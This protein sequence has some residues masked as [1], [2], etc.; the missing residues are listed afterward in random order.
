M[1]TNKERI[2]R[3]ETKLGGMQNE[4]QRL[5]QGMN[6]KFQ[7]APNQHDQTSTSRIGQGESVGERQPIPPRVAKLDF[8]K[9][10]GDY[11]TEWVN[12]V[13]EANQWWHWLCRSYQEDGQAVTW[14]TFVDELWARF[15]PTE[16][17][18]F[19]EALSRMQQT[20]T[21]RDYQKEFE[22]L[23]NKV[24]GWTQRALVAIFIGGLKPEISE[25]IRLF[26]QKT[27]KEAISRARMKDE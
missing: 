16:C 7:K 15:G 14:N 8:P 9:Y 10:S 25:E 1:S 17:E 19:D 20:G 3:V 2:K 23:G 13:T 5:S 11:P 4:K 27:L 21:L 12:R 6:D 24:H 26:R 18:N 22:R